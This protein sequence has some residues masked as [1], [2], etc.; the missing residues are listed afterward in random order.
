V[1]LTSN[2]KSVQQKA[3]KLWQLQGKTTCKHSDEN[4]LCV[5]GPE[6]KKKTAT[7]GEH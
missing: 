4:M 1:G 6:G 2:N 5:G 3:K 7:E